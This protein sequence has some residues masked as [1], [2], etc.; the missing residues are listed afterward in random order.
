[1]SL[2]TVAGE[3]LTELGLKKPQIT[4]DYNLN[5]RHNYFINIEELS[6]F[7]L[8]GDDQKNLLFGNLS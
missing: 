7:F 8:S 6:S 4:I 1:L 2:L 5:R 3:E